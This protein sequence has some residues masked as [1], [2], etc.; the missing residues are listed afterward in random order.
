M[1]TPWCE[2][3]RFLAETQQIASKVAHEIWEKP[4]L[5]MIQKVSR[6][7]GLKKN[8]GEE[9]RLCVFC[10]QHVFFFFP[11]AS[12]F[13]SWWWTFFEITD[14]S[15]LSWQPRVAMLCSN[16]LRRPEL[17]SLHISMRFARMMA[18]HSMRTAPG[19]DGKDGVPVISPNDLEFET[20]T[21][22]SCTTVQPF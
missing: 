20:T 11:F 12:C 5:A 2:A 7:K 18:L 9:K 22:M 19:R 15:T 17:H 6:Q 21:S 8:A 16:C 3:E 14:C 1:C 10:L 13:G 4:E